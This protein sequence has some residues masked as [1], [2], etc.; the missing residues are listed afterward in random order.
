MKGGRIQISS[1]ELK[2]SFSLSSSEGEDGV[3]RLHKVAYWT[4]PYEDRKD[5][6]KVWEETKRLVSLGN[7]NFPKASGTRVAHVRPKG[8]DGSDKTELP[9]GNLFLTQCFWLNK[10][11]VQSVISK[12]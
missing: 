10:K 7:T 4:M 5:A 1:N 2:T 6:E 8:R 12:L 3:E 9:N 11:Y